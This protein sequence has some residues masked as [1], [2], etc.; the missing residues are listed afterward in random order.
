MRADQEAPPSLLWKIQTPLPTSLARALPCLTAT[1]CSLPPANSCM[2]DPGCRQNFSYE[3][4]RETHFVASLPWWYRKACQRGLNEPV[5]RICPN[6]K[7]RPEEVELIG[8]LN[9]FQLQVMY[10]SSQQPDR[11]SAA[12]GPLLLTVQGIL[13]SVFSRVESWQAF[14]WVCQYFYSSFL[15][16]ETLSIFKPLYALMFMWFMW[17]NS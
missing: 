11:G 14:F 9:S 8:W 12:L 13:I 6:G 10:S 2:V 3:E 7:V 16:F 15:D 1:R 4:V 17:L 5:C